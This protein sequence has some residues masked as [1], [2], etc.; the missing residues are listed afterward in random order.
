MLA[1]FHT[2]SSQIVG[3]GST[4]YKRV[5]HATGFAFGIL[6]ILFIVFQW[7]GMRVQ[8]IVALPIGLARACSSGGGRG[9]GG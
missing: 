3:S 7:Q 4:E 2:R 5:A 9:A 1:A 8:L 6:A